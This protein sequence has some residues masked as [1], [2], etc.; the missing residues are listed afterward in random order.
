MVAKF[1]SKVEVP[2]DH[3][4]CWVW[5]ASRVGGYGQFKPAHGVT[6]VRAHRVAYELTYGPIPDGLHVLHSCDNRGCVNPAHLRA[7]THAENMADMAARG[8]STR[9]RRRRTA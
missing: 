5:R 8:R 9:G 6:P 7:G 1:W 3:T 2:R 4:H